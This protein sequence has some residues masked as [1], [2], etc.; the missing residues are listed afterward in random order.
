MQLKYSLT[1]AYEKQG[2]VLIDEPEVHLH[3][4][5]QRLIMPILTKVFPNVQ[6]IVATHSPFVLNS[7]SN[8]VVFDL[9]RRERIEDLSEYSYEALAEGY[10]G[11]KTDSSDIT[12]RLE[13]MRELI[14]KQGLNQT[15]QLEL[16]NLLCEFDKIPEPVA[17]T[18][19]AD[20]N[21]LSL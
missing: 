17:P 7:L 13:R 12:L 8:A 19:V 9:E 4:Q 11:V 5:L 10:F 20:Y 15:E 18:I 16:K 2:I 3:L 1:R 21:L 6:F 14:R